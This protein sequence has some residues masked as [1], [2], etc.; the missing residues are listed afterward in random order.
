MPQKE[1]IAAVDGHSIRVSNSW[2]GGAKLYIDGE[3]RDTSNK[4]FAGSSAPALSARLEQGKP[5]SPLI[6][7]FMKAVFT[8][9][10]KI[11]VDGR[12]VAGDVL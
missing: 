1:W 11:C 7:V 9:K 8:V 6:E 10:A 4:T 3:C 2:T 12:Q 5:D